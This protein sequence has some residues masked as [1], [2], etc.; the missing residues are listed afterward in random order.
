MAQADHWALV[1]EDLAPFR[2]QLHRL[3]KKSSAQVALLTDTAGHLLTFAGQRPEVDLQAFLVLCAGDH[4]AS[5][6]MAEMLGEN[7][8]QALYHQSEHHQIYITE[9]G[10]TL[11]LVLLFNRQSTL[12]LVRWAVK[13]H[14]KGLV[15]ALDQAG[16]LARERTKVPV[17]P[18]HREP[19]AQGVD[20]ALDA[21]FDT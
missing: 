12:G 20:D 14:I 13:K 17:A 2:V 4:A 3:L 10:P 16:K 1:E 18:G 11:L 8:F 21:F 15:R 19:T 6:E 5:R 7:R 9:I